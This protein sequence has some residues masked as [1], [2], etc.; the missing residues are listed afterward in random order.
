MLS[1]G[2]SFKVRLH[3][4][5]SGQ[6][7]RARGYPEYDDPGRGM[8]G[9]GP[10]AALGCSARRRCWTW[11][12]AGCCRVRTAILCWPGRRNAGVSPPV[13]YDG[14]RLC[15]SWMAWAV[16]ARHGRDRSPPGAAAAGTADPSGAGRSVEHPESQAGLVL[17]GLPVTPVPGRS[18]SATA[19]PDGMNLAGGRCR[20]DAGRPSCLYVGLYRVWPA[21]SSCGSERIMALAFAAPHPPGWRRMGARLAGASVPRD[22]RRRGAVWPPHP[23]AHIWKQMQA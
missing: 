18:W 12:M 11:P 21:G 16:N 3:A 17:R 13:P 7:G 14:R 1:S 20:D 23:A 6:P 19:G 10:P 4:R 2:N 5:A 15:C 9:P 22:D 8:F